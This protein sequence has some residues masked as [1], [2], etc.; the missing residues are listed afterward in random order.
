LQGAN[1]A[2]MLVAVP[3]LLAARGV[4]EQRISLVVAI[5]L[6]PS[7][8]GF[9][10]SPILD[11]RFSRRFYAIVLALLAGL[12]QFLALVCLDNLIWLT[13]LLFL[14]YT[15]VM[16]FVAA[17]GG[18]FAGM[19]GSEAK[20]GLGAWL[21]AWNVGGGGIVALFAVVLLRQ[22]PFTLGAG[23]LSLTLF[24]PL[25]LLFWLPAKPADHRLAGESFRDFLRDLRAV[26]RKR[27][28]LRTLLLFTLPAASFSLTN[29][30]AGLG[31][32]F[33]ASERVVS[34]TGGSGIIL[35]GTAGSLLV[36]LLLKRVAP[37]PLYLLIGGTG[38]LLTLSLLALP[39]VPASFALAI[40]GENAFQ[41]AAFA[42][43]GI[44]ILRGIGELNPFAATQFALLNA[45]SSLP[46]I[47]M[48]VVDGQAYRLSGLRGSLLADAGLS[49]IACGILALFVLPHFGASEPMLTAAGGAGPGTRT[50]SES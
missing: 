12:L 14:T 48:Q 3:Q 4:P 32:D 23:L 24:M 46:I 27:D 28:V 16:L 33:S 37:R 36:P 31:S 11:W 43:E 35:A 21:A 7:V 39:R 25:P 30:L 44:I 29:T 15:A 5:G 18:W 41:S 1:G 13:A 10:F 42:I 26:L 19:V 47:Y 2:I 34:V 22:I 20:K 38:G 45:A 6:L 8:T 50:S 49:L 9:L 17:T 40:I